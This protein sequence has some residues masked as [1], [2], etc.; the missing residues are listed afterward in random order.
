MAIDLAKAISAITTS[1]GGSVMMAPAATPLV[2]IDN[3]KFLRSGHVIVGEEANYPEAFSKFAAPHTTVEWF[4]PK[5]KASAYLLLKEVN[6]F[7]F[8]V[9]QGYGSTVANRPAPELFYTKEGDYWGQANLIL[10]VGTLL[11][12]VTFWGNKYWI[13]TSV[14]L[15]SS[16]D[17]QSWKAENSGSVTSLDSFAGKLVNSSSTSVRHFDGT[18]WVTTPLP[19]AELNVSSFVWQS[20]KV[21]NGNYILLGS[22]GGHV[23]FSTDLVT[24]KV[25]T[26]IQPTI[27]PK[28]IIYTGSK[29]I[30]STTTGVIYSSLDLLT[31]E[32]TQATS[33]VTGDI[34]YHDGTLYGLRNGS[35]LVYYSKDPGPTLGQ[36]WASYTNTTTTNSSSEQPTCT[37]TFKG[38]VFFA[39]GNP[40]SSSMNPNLFATKDSGLTFYDGHDNGSESADYTCITPHEGGWLKLDSRGYSWSADGEVW[41]FIA[42]AAQKSMVYSTLYSLNSKRVV[43]IHQNR[44]TL[45]MDKGVTQTLSPAPITG[46]I[47][48]AVMFKGFLFALYNNGG[49]ART[50]DGLNWDVVQSTSLVAS[51]GQ[52]SITAA[53]GIL[54]VCLPTST[55]TFTPKLFVYDGSSFKLIAFEPTV[56]STQPYYLVGA[57]DFFILSSASYQLFSK[58]LSTWYQLPI[59]LSVVNLIYVE[60]LY[61]AHTTTGVYQTFDMLT[62]TRVAPFNISGSTSNS[63]RFITLLGNDQIFSCS[64]KHMLRGRIRRA[65]GQRRAY[66]EGNSI[67]HL[68]IK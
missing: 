61:I 14:G 29:Y 31:W 32:V 17:L 68:R 13:S 1:I 58:D 25:G 7:L 18:Q 12:D 53:N 54:V 22:N 15:Y 36:T 16:S 9:T 37:L 56:T 65:L 46:N 10:P 23:L 66:S 5:V 11:N 62:W 48:D 27:V 63:R 42:A 34:S 2:E 35:A 41:T 24:W 39:G 49:V 40:N 60:G 47:I 43:H 51:W 52:A 8:T 3:A 50:E 57:G 28:C 67:Q 38:K 21:L 30:L 33:S 45:I 20:A 26:G 6:G 19:L 64:F 59:A 55:T 44:A 4:G